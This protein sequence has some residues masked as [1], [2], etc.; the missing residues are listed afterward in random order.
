M[1]YFPIIL[2]HSPLFCIDQAFRYVQ[3][4]AEYKLFL[5]GAFIPIAVKKHGDVNITHCNLSSH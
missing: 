1:P 5:L 3:K 4:G 2:Y